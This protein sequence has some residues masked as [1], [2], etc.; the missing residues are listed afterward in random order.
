MNIG[1]DTNILAYAEGVNGIDMQQTALSVIKSIPAA[2]LIIPVQVLAELYRVLVIKAKRPRAAAQH[3]VMQ[4][5]SFHVVEE[6][7]FE[8]F[9]NAA[10]L[11]TAHQLAIFDAMILATAADANCDF[12][13]SEDMHSGFVWQGCRVMN[14]FS[15][16][17]ATVRS[18]QF[19]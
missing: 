7:T 14:P 13:L 15:A 5:T 2:D 4:W 6:V 19:S 10:A 12:L 16:E 9:R 1:I 3:A 11:A 18:Q 8:R 17:F